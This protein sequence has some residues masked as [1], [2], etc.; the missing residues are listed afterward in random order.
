MNMKLS[1]INRFIQPKRILDI[2]CNVGQFYKSAKS[3]WPNA[4]YYLIDG[5]E[6]VEENLR[7]LGVA[8]RIEL[9]SDSVKKVNLYKNKKNS[10]CTG[11]SIYRETSEHYVDALVQIVEMSTTTLDLLFDH[12]KIQFDL[13]KL[14][15]QGSEIDIIKG[16]LNLIKKAKY[17]ILETSLIEWNKDSPDENNVINFM[18]TIGFV[19]DNVIDTHYLNGELIQ[20]DIL[21]KNTI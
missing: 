15:T 7:T 9:L 3:V 20:N 2:G 21:F 16:G 19:A 17:L 14:D 13:I 11:T 8:Y 18:K 10:K 12:E 4:Y 6:S 1:Y 5:N